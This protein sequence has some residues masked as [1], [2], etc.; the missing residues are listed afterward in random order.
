MHANRRYPHASRQ[1]QG[2]DP[3]TVA[4]HFGLRHPLAKLARE[5]CRSLGHGRARHSACGRCWEQA[6]RDD[7]RFVVECDLPRTLVLDPHYV[8]V[9]AVDRACAGKRVRLTRAEFVAAVARLHAD[10]LPCSQIAYR[11]GRS[12]TV[13]RELL[14]RMQARGVAA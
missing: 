1:T 13:V 10:G 4:R 5:R 7:E 8:D 9:V 14:D 12:H 3:H 11:L 2:R 6:L